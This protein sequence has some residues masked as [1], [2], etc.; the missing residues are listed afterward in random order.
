MLDRKR[1]N[2]AMTTE[3]IETTN[4]LLTVSEVSGIL[5]VDPTTVRRW[6]KVGAL[7]AVSLPHAGKRESYRIKRATL[8]LLL[9]AKPVA[10]AVEANKSH[11]K[12]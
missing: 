9:N 11:H 4:E 3:T 7:E 8:D 2:T 1:E 5:R 12:H 10:K 6:L